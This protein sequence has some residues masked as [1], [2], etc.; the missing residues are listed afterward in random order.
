MFDSRNNPVPYWVHSGNEA[1]TKTFAAFFTS[2]GISGRGSDR[3]LENWPWRIGHHV[4]QHS[5]GRLEIQQ[6]LKSQ[7]PPSP[8]QKDN[9]TRFTALTVLPPPVTR[10]SH[11]S[12]PRHNTSLGSGA[13]CGHPDLVREKPLLTP[14]YSLTVPSGAV[15]SL[16]S[17]WISSVIL[18][19]AFRMSSWLLYGYSSRKLRPLT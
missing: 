7:R 6:H 19:N 14:N 13:S 10:T 15:A 3:V 5:N 9:A 11:T 16:S 1:R 12:R 17:S 18:V 4:L 8:I 2:G